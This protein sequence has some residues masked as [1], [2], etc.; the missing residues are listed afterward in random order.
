LVVSARTEAAALEQEQ[1]VHVRVARV[2]ARAGVEVVGR[3]RGREA[4]AHAV[5][6]ER[7]HAVGAD[8]CACFVDEDPP[9]TQ[10]GVEAPVRGE[11]Q[12]VLRE[13]HVRRQPADRV[14]QRVERIDH[15]VLVDVGGRALGE[16]ELQPLRQAR[17]DL[18]ERRLRDPARAAA[19]FEL[20]RAPVDGPHL[21]IAGERGHELLR[22]RQERLG[23]AGKPGT[24]IRMRARA[25]SPQARAQSSWFR[26]GSR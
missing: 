2:D 16:V 14:G 6:P 7:D 19:V 12:V 21:E 20:V 11:A 23:A 1:A 22:E 8:A 3:E 9:V 10:I 17:V 15:A 13:L 24:R 26:S 4:R 25:R 18:V 5:A